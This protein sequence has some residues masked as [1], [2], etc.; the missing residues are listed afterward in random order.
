MVLG[1]VFEQLHV[2]WPP[3]QRNTYGERTREHGWIL[4]LRLVVERIFRRQPESLTFEHHDSG[5]YH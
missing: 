3:P 1:A 5:W 4:D 2:D